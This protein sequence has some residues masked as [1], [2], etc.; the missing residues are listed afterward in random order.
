MRSR[1][2]DL[3]ELL[4]AP[5]GPIILIIERSDEAVKSNSF[6]SRNNHVVCGKLLVRIIS[7]IWQ[8]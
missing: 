6:D 5:V 4:P 2:A 3:T 1:P 7:N 8:G